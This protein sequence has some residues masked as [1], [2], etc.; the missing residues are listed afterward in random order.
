[1][2]GGE[3]IEILHVE[4]AEIRRGHDPY[5]AVSRKKKKIK[6]HQCHLAPVLFYVWKN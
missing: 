6:K 2:T 1:V 3:A 5:G 4:T